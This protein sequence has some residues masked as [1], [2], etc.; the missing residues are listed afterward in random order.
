MLRFSHFFIQ[1]L[2]KI[3]LKTIYKIYNKNVKCMI[4]FTVILFYLSAIT[5]IMLGI[6][7]PEK[8]GVIKW[9]FYSLGLIIGLLILLFK[10]EEC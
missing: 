4:N 8:H 7:I 10:D 5:C 3:T 2:K 6:T 1:F 9:T